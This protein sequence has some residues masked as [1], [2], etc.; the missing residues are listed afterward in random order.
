M[1]VFRAPPDGRRLR[2]Y[3]KNSDTINAG[4]RAVARRK[5]LKR[6]YG[7]SLEQWDELFEKQDKRCA[8]CQSDNPRR[9]SGWA[10]DH[11]HETGEVRGILCHPC[12]VVLGFIRDDPA[13]LFALEMYLQA[14]HVR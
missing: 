6:K 8:V 5:A 9:T 1:L 3:H 11:N 2:Y 10:L 12:N 14:P 7:I 13:V 4:V